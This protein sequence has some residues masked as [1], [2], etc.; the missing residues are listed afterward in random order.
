M[1][2][3]E[4]RQSEDRTYARE[5]AQHSRDTANALASV[6]REVAAIKED[7]NEDRGRRERGRELAV[8]VFLIVLAA[9]AAYGFGVIQSGGP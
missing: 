4:Q 7:A 2:Y 3:I 1:D 6:V 9:A 8:R 5:I